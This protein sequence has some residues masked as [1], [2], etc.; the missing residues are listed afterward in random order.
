MR[1]TLHLS[2]LMLLGV[3]TSNAQV[4]VGAKAGYSRFA[5]PGMNGATLDAFAEVPLG[6]SESFSLRS[7]F[8][9]RLP[10]KYTDYDVS[11]LNLMSY[12]PSD[13]VYN[14]SQPGLT[15][16]SKFNDIGIFSE[17][18][19][20]FQETPGESA[21]YITARA[22]I[23]YSHIKRWSDDPYTEELL[24]SNPK[25]KRVNQLSYSFGAGFGY[26]HLFGEKMLLFSDMIIGLPFISA[27]DSLPSSSLSYFPAVYFSLN[28]GFKYALFN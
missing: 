2:I 15:V 10:M 24:A 5:D 22:T 16:H 8:F 26:Q 6:N 17:F 27:D 11:P 23:S 21:F 4:F 1:K 7:G 25:R 20:F 13:Y 19:Y 12:T 28:V 18:S 3:Q 9:A 14:P